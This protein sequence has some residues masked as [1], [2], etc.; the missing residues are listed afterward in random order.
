ME[1]NVRVIMQIVSHS[2]NTRLLMSVLMTQL[3]YISTVILYSKAVVVLGN[4]VYTLKRKACRNMTK[5]AVSL[6]NTFQNIKLQKE[7]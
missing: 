3:Q 1:Q 7:H 6:I 5:I 2:Q 4:L